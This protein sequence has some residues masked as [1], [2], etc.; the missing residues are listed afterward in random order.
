[1]IEF[2]CVRG[3]NRS[4]NRRETA[5]SFHRR[6]DGWIVRALCVDGKSRSSSNNPS[7]V[8]GACSCDLCV[9]ELCVQRRAAPRRTA[10]PSPVRTF[11]S[12]GRLIQRCARGKAV[13][14]F[15]EPPLQDDCALGALAC[16]RLGSE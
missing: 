15:Q 14:K 7:G 11:V 13:S 4:G 6:H 2:L 10:A 3:G 16:G 9:W 12:N 1:M 5:A 8:D